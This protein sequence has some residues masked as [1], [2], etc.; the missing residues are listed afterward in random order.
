MTDDMT[1]QMPGGNVAFDAATGQNRIP[2]KG[3]ATNVPGLLAARLLRCHTLSFG[4]HQATYGPAT[5]W[6]IFHQGTGK[7]VLWLSYKTRRE[8]T[9][10]ANLLGDL[11]WSQQIWP[12]VTADRLARILN[13]TDEQVLE[14]R[15]A[16]LEY[17]VQETRETLH[18]V[19]AALSEA[20][21]ELATM[22]SID[23]Y[24]V[25]NVTRGPVYREPGECFVMPGEDTHTFSSIERASHTVLDMVLEY[26]HDLSSARIYRLAPVPEHE[27]QKAFFAVVKEREEEVGEWYPDGDVPLWLTLRPMIKNHPPACAHCFKYPMCSHRDEPDYAPGGV[28][29]KA[30]VVT[31]DVQA[32]EVQPWPS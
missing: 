11:D 2:W 12:D 7:R 20:Q 27:L 30:L 22:Q 1:T 3:Y 4:D 31:G 29:A 28:C 17:Q 16:E 5:T 21:A 18:E 32:L 10:K 19:T 15:V 6:G 24:V 26:G 9:S 8:T 13:P 23:Q 25:V 14:D